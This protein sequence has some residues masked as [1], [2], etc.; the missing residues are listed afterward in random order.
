MSTDNKGLQEI[1]KELATKCNVSKV[2][3][4]VDLAMTSQ[5]TEASKTGSNKNST[6]ADTEFQSKQVT[7]TSLPNISRIP[8]K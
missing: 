2:K 3:A 4:I 6:S 1:H 8:T 7:K 5:V